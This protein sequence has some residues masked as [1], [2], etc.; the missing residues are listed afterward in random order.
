M[1]GGA[2]G[3]TALF[4]AGLF[5]AGQDFRAGAAEVG[6]LVVVKLVLHPLLTWWLAYQVFGLEGVWAAAA[7]YLL[8]SAQQYNRP[9]YYLIGVVSLALSVMNFY[10][11]LRSFQR[12]Q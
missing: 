8:I 10:R 12:R 5:M 4:A 6:W 1:L 7:V 11:L 3:P 2:F 9:Q